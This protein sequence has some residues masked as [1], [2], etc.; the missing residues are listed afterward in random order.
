MRPI[1]ETNALAALAVIALSVSAS[2]FAVAGVPCSYQDLMP[3]YEKF[4]AATVNA[5]PAER[6][7][8]FLTQIAA[9]FPDYYSTEVY[10]DEA[11]LKM[12]ALQFFGP[13]QSAV[14]FPGVPPLN[15]QRLSALAGVVGSEF[16]AQQRRFMQTF[17]DFTCD[18]TV[19]FGVSLLTF[20]GHPTDIARKHH[21]LFG[22]DT[23]ALLH[24]PVD[25][26][27]FFDHELFHLY[28]RQVMGY[29]APEGEDPAWWTMWR[30]GLATYVSQ[31]MNPE[32]DAQQV[33][34]YPRDIVTRME[35]DLTHA[36][37]LMLQDIEKRGSVADRWFLANQ[38]VDGLPTRADYFV[39]YLFA[40]SEGDGKA[41][42][43]LAR[44]PPD[45]VHADAV[46]FLT[47]IG[48]A[49]GNQALRP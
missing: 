25:M 3:A 27:A 10:G 38:S 43:Q 22:V 19:E 26:A 33:L 29:R 40:K 35:K 30:E 4:A 18:T 9:R 20:D 15:P 44:I 47:R 21:L 11:R 24:V 34:W 16:A 36:A 5:Q 1:K 14:I 28:H 42:P 13:A 45:Q 8:A 23:I 6:A 37:L 39:G 7:A 49:P 46:R 41:L 31:R 2:S 17:P 48:H 32:L 12:R